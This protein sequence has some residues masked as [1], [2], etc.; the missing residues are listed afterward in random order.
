MVETNKTPNLRVGMGYDLHKLVAGRKLFLGGV[1]IPFSKGLKG[2]SDAD[3]LLHAICDGLLG[4]CGCDDIGVH[5]PDT[6]HRFK[7]LS[8]AELAKQVCKIISEKNSV[9]IVNIDA[10]VVC[11]KPNISEYRKMITDSIAR[12]LGIDSS[13]INIKAKT[14][15]A[16]SLN[17][18][19]S[20]AVVL[21]E[22][23]NS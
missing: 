8:G 12:I 9:E 11:D 17:S 5:F 3:V 23:H 4:A 1:C 19:S 21:V 14:T 15:E 13:K 10:I 2:H 22:I 20:Y 6:N 7:G 16:T 18:I